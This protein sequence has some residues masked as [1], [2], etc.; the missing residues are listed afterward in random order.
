L[1]GDAMISK[2][3]KYAL[4]ALEYLAINSHERPILI[5][6]LAAAEKIPK[7]FLEFILLTLRKGGVLTSRI[8]RGGGYRLAR[9]PAEIT[10]GKLVAILEGG[11]SLVHCLDGGGGCQ[12]EDGNDPASCGIHLT[13]VDMKKSINSVLEATTL[14]DIIYKK[15]SANKFRLNIIDYSI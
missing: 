6:E 15:D 9:D 7:K 3:T 1:I 8:G 2:K 5:S 13:M 10:V 14:A 12:C 4:K 11:F